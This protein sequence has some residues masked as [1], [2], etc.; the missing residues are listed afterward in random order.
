[1]ITEVYTPPQT[2]RKPFIF[3]LS[4]GLVHQKFSHLNPLLENRIKYAVFHRK[5]M[6]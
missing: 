4:G 6:G 3:R 1:V 5:A 2:V